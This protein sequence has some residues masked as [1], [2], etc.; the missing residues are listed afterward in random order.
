MAK[1]H[2]MYLSRED[3]YADIIIPPKQVI[4]LK[5]E[6]TEE[7]Y[8]ELHRY[9][10]SKLGAFK[11]SLTLPK[12]LD[13]FFTNIVTTMPTVHLCINDC[14]YYTHEHEAY[15]YER[16]SYGISPHISISYDSTNNIYSYTS[17][18]ATCIISE[19]LKLDGYVEVNYVTVFVWKKD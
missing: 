7:N 11:N 16:I 10:Q 6:S 17:V 12:Q 19:L 13:R 15:S 3:P 5:D 18:E 14:L 4:L 2:E 8:T 9:L 1:K